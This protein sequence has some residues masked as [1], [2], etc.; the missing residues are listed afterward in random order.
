M[1]VVKR[2]GHLEPLD[3]TKIQ[4]YTSAAVK[5]LSNVSQSELEVDAH[6][7]FR[8]GITTAE[9]QTTLIKTA[10]DKIDID[11]PNWT[12][13]AARLFLYDLY[14]KVSGYCGYIHLKDYFLRGEQEGRILLGL[15]EMYDLEELNSYISP[16][17]DHNFNYLGVKTLYDRYLIKDSNNDPIELP[18]HMF[19][20]IAMFLAQRETDKM[21]WAKKFY[22]MMSKFEVMMATPTLS[23]ARTP[24]HQMSSCYIGSTPDNI[25]GI[26]DDYKEMAL[27]S[28]FGGGIGWDWSNVRSMGSFIDGHKNAAGG[29]IPFLKITNDIAIGV[30]QLGKKLKIA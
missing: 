1:N 22:D 7:Q 26:F 17:R 12:Y 16:E 2:R 5:G 30:D 18:Q 24:R 23:N 29:S 20:G 21:Y 13:V 19:M 6:L 14:H 25:E 10:V 8:D 27:L 28:K 11:Q 4:K 3:I 9:I 15:K